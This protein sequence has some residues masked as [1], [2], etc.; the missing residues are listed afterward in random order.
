MIIP[1][2]TTDQE[3]AAKKADAAFEKEI[4]TLEKVQRRVW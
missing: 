1:K 4:D 3:A 2:N